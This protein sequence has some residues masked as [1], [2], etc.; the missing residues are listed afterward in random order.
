MAAVNV[1]G[2]ANFNAFSPEGQQAYAL[3]LRRTVAFYKGLIAAQ[4]VLGELEGAR[5]ELLELLTARL[6][7]ATIETVTSALLLMRSTL[8]RRPELEPA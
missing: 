8:S 6:D 7:P 2:N 5:D 3:A 4:P 1:A